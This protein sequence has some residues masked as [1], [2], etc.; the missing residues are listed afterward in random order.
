MEYFYFV[1]TDAADP[2]RVTEETRV[3]GLVVCRGM[4]ICLLS[5]SSGMEEIANPFTDAD[6]DGNVVN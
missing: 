4:Q 6:D 3:L 1:F 2:T 5:P